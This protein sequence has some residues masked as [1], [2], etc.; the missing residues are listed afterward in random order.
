MKKPTFV[1]ALAALLAGATGVPAQTTTDYPTRAVTLIVP[2]AAG[3]GTDVFSRLFADRLGKMF[4]QTFIV[5]NKPGANGINGTAIAA[6]AEPDGYTLLFTYAAAYVGNPALMSNLPYD[7]EKAF[8]P[9]A[10]IGS[11]GNMLLV[12]PDFPAKNLPEF[13][14]YVK[15]RPGKLNYCSW[16]Q[17]SGGHFLMESLK[18]QAGLDM[19]HIPY[20]GNALCMQGLLGNQVET[21]IGDVS[22]NIQLVK[23]G[24]LRALAY[25]GPRRLDVLPDVPTM[26]ESGYPFTLYAWYGLFAPAGTSKPIVDKLNAAVNKLLADPEMKERLHAL[27]LTDLPSKTP[28]QFAADIRQDLGEWKKAAKDFNIKLE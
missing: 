7:V 18:K 3:G 27:N 14:A 16:G 22:S 2:T 10:Q 11:I 25:G 21:A 19:Q 8:I 13:V 15:A 4:N 17:G 24:K 1:L 9:I 20:K 23:S 12:P 6:R 26:T 5:D 28:E